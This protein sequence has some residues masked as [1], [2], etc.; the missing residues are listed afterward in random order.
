[1]FKQPSFLKGIRKSIDN[2]IWQNA[3]KQGGDK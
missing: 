2:L 1:M 3:C